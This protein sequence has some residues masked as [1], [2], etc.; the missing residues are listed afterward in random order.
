ME[1]KAELFTEEA[2]DE[3]LEFKYQKLLEV[4]QGNETNN[5]LGYYQ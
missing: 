2:V 5:K 3:H 4:I 1:E